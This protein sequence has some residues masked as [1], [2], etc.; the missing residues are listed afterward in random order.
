M[1]RKREVLFTERE[2]AHLERRLKIEGHYAVRLPRPAINNQLEI[3]KPIGHRA[4]ITD[5]KIT[6]TDH[7][8]S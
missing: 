7:P 8:A 6:S 1:Y 2:H 5:A 4:K 3:V